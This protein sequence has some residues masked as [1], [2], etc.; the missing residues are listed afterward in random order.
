[1]MTTGRVR[2]KIRDEHTV[3]A[4]LTRL[5]HR[6]NSSTAVLQQ[7][8]EEG[9]RGQEKTPPA[10][11]DLGVSRQDCVDYFRIVSYRWVCFV[12]VF[13]ELYLHLCLGNFTVCN[14]KSYTSENKHTGRAV[15]LQQYSSMCYSK[16]G[17]ESNR[18]QP[19][20]NHFTPTPTP[21]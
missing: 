21:T 19:G 6:S 11:Q 3:F 18:G 1:M 14:K 17:E 2:R 13:I 5:H 9:S 10:P 15:C 16:T 8:R 4:T 12:R 7:D 20:L